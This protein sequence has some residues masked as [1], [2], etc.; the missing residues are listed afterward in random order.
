MCR[1][2]NCFKGVEGVTFSDSGSSAKKE[3]STVNQA[4]LLAST[5][6]SSLLLPSLLYKRK[7]IVSCPPTSRSNTCCNYYGGS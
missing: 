7:H 1:G 4:S 5:E 6:C 3:Y 2:F